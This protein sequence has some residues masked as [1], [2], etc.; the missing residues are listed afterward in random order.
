MK[1]DAP[2]F[3]I[4]GFFITTVL[5]SPFSAHG[6][7]SRGKFPKDR[8]KNLKALK[9]ISVTGAS[10]TPIDGL[11]S[12]SLGDLQGVGLEPPEY[13]DEV[14]YGE[15]KNVTYE[16][17][18]EV[19][20]VNGAFDASFLKNN[21]KLR[22]EAEGF[23]T[24]TRLKEKLKIGALIR[25]DVMSSVAA[26]TR[27]PGKWSLEPGTILVDEYNGFALKITGSTNVNGEDYYKVTSPEIYEVVKDFKIPPQAVYVTRDNLIPASDAISSSILQPSRGEAVD[28]INEQFPNPLIR[29]GFNNTRLIGFKKDGTSVEVIA[30][31]VLVLDKIR[32]DGS[33]S[34]WSGYHFQI[35]SGEGIG[36]DLEVLAQ[37]DEEISIP[38]F[39]LDIPVPPIARVYGGIYL[40]VGINGEFKITVSVGEWTKFGAGLKGGTAFCVPYSFRPIGYFEKGFIGDASFNGEINGELTVGPIA[41]LELFGFDVVGAGLL[42]GFG[43]NTVAAYEHD[44]TLD[45]D[46]FRIDADFYIPLYLYFTL[47]KRFNLVNQHFMLAQFHK[48]YSAGQDPTTSDIRKFLITFHEACAY[49]KTVWGE[50]KDM[51]APPDQEGNPS[52]LQNTEIEISV[53]RG[54]QIITYN[55]TTNENGFFAVQNVDLEKGDEVRVSRIGNIETASLPTYPTFPF[56]K[57]T[58]RYVDFF[59][60][61]SRGQVAPAR[62]VDWDA[63]S[64]RTDGQIVY[65][66]INYEG[67]IQYEIQGESARPTVQSDENGNFFME[68]DFKPGRQ[69]TAH[70]SWHGFD[71]PS[72]PVMPDTDIGYRQIKVAKS[73]STHVADDGSTKGRNI[74]ELNIFIQN[75]RGTRSVVGGVLRGEVDYYLVTPPY[76]GCLPF[77]SV[78][79]SPLVGTREFQAVPVAIPSNGYGVSKIQRA[80]VTKWRWPVDEDAA[81][82]TPTSR[83]GSMTTIDASPVTSLEPTGQ[84]PSIHEDVVFGSAIPEPLV[85]GGFDP[86]LIYFVYETSINLINSDLCQAL[87]EMPTDQCLL[88][89][90]NQQHIPAL[91]SVTPVVSVV[92][93]LEFD[94]EGVTVNIKNLDEVDYAPDCGSTPTAGI[95][96]PVQEAL[97]DHIWSRINPTPVTDVTITHVNE[98]LW[99]DIGENLNTVEPVTTVTPINEGTGGTTLQPVNVQPIGVH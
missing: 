24:Q 54:D 50:I 99:V 89:Q 11:Q 57:L 10:I 97:M 80:L 70:I 5:F 40:N 23:A 56:K 88:I 55:S 38:L 30:D 91:L 6:E 82:S 39:A 69:V 19:T 75:L 63:T 90:A 52:P 61:S 43:F 64:A 81:S 79:V 51:D 96:N 87:E 28:E 48:V 41:G 73:A 14:N 60:D 29:L 33:Y 66:W 26:S 86:S 47:I 74:Y 22:E 25:K 16:L 4:L 21:I 72:E 53:K 13:F 35:S 68:H 94:Y 67:D 20:V 1:I 78:T 49:R 27:S 95:E 7:D 71:V 84:I 42:V 85:L 31:G 59:D 15:F 58:I 9:P 12:I 98:A 83:L 65:K 77:K 44:L 92:S 36:F 93:S 8:F 3:L 76:K 2:S 62:V 45:V 18:P 46:F 17:R 37:I 32:V 34:C